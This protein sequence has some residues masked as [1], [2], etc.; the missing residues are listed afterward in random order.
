MTKWKTGLLK[1]AEHVAAAID[2]TKHSRP[3]W[4]PICIAYCRV[5]AAQAE[6]EKVIAELDQMQAVQDSRASG[7]RITLN[8][9]AKP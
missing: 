9:E 3:G 7:V 8:P 2:E 6:L 1:A 4:M 5:E